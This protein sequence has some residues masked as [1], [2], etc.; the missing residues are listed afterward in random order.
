MKAAGAK[1]PDQLLAWI[2]EGTL[3][4][5]AGDGRIIDA[6]LFQIAYAGGVSTVDTADV[7]TEAIARLETKPTADRQAIIDRLVAKTPT[8]KDQKRDATSFRRYLQSLTDEELEAEAARWAPTKPPASRP[9][10]PLK[11]LA[12]EELQDL[13]V[14]ELEARAAREAGETHKPVSQPPVSRSQGAEPETTKTY[15]MNEGEI[16]E[17]VERFAGHPILGPTARFLE[18]FKE[19]VNKKSDGWPY[20]KQPPAHAAGRLMN[21]LHGYLRAGMGPIEAA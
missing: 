4:E 19:Q 3:D 20:W 6:A 15:W 16:E 2:N 7:R 10:V 9:A 5:H 8:T 21:L 11:D 1:T 12:S 13:P 14:E 17:A 18:A